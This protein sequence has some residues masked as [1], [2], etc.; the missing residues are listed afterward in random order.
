MNVYDTK[1]SMVI[2]NK[3]LPNKIAMGNIEI[4]FLF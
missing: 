2:L 4:Q 3:L 1:H